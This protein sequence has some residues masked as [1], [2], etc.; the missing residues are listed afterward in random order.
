[1]YTDIYSDLK[2]DQLIDPA[3]IVADGNSASVDMQGYDSLMF[4]VNVGAT[5]DTLDANNYIELEVEESDDDSSFTDVA[6]ADLHK[7][8]AG[9]NDGTF[10][11]I[12]A[13]DEDDA[14]YITGYRGNSRYV[15]VVIN[16]TGTHTNGT[17][18]AVTAVRGNAVFKPVNAQS[19]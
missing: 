14:V 19:N 17:P 10:A 16:V 11:L 12:N 9:S 15:R 6:D 4:I 1:M 7:W 2:V 8:V 13:A 3:D 5:G 18:Q